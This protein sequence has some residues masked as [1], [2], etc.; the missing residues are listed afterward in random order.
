MDADGAILIDLKNQKPVKKIRIKITGTVSEG[1]LAEISQVEFL[2]DMKDRIP[3]PAQNIPQNVSAQI[4]SEMFT[5]TWDRELNITGYEVSVTH[6]G[7]TELMESTENTLTVREFDG[8]ELLNYETY[9]VKVRAV[10]GSWKSGYSQQ[11]SVMPEPEGP[12]PAPENISIE[13]GYKS[14]H[15]SWKKMKDTKSYSL[16]FRQT[17]M[18][19][20][21]VL[22]ELTGTSTSI[23]G[24]E[25]RT[26][27]EIYMVGHNPWG[28]S[29]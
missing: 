9:L 10:N 5:L 25:D 11:I 29:R 28:E 8:K 19:D 15:V 27:Y 7:K 6:E 3:P 16:Y 13:G 4:G 22:E 26:E 18:E 2:G 23:N 21:T 1:N 14:L 17:G 12:P 20:F 24:L